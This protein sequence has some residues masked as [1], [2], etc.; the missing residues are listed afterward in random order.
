MPRELMHRCRRPRQSILN[1]NLNGQLQGQPRRLLR[2]VLPTNSQCCSRVSSFLLRSSLHR[3]TRDGA[4]NNRGS[5]LDCFG[6]RRLR[7][8]GRQSEEEFL[9]TVAARTRWL[10]LDINGDSARRPRFRPCGETRLKI[11]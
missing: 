10:N 4:L 2:V 5:S 6:E 9:G 1:Q 3:V 8:W 7:V 11:P